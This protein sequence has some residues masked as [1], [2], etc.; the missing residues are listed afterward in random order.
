MEVFDDRT[1]AIWG[2]FRRRARCIS[3]CSR[4]RVCMEL[5]RR[6]MRGQLARYSHNSTFSPLITT[7]KTRSRTHQ[8]KSP[9]LCSKPT[10]LQA[11]LCFFSLCSLSL[12]SLAAPGRHPLDRTP[13]RTYTLHVA[14]RRGSRSNQQTSRTQKKGVQVAWGSRHHELRVSVQ[15]EGPIVAAYASSLERGCGRAGSRVRAR[16]R[17]MRCFAHPAC[18]P[19][20]LPL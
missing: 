4:S 7:I 9:A 6:Q 19:S 14:G 16:E 18:S 11:S 5:A 17:R 15:E 3:A 10:A 1:R 2:R 8:Q 20:P 12:E 13:T